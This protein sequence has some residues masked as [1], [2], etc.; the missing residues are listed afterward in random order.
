MNSMSFG[1]DFSG[2]TINL[3]GLVIGGDYAALLLMLFS[4]CTIAAI[5]AVINFRVFKAAPAATIERVPLKDQIFALGTAVASCLVVS[6][7]IYFLLILGM[8]ARSEIREQGAYAAP[9]I[10]VGDPFTL[11]IA[12]IFF[13]G[14]A[15]LM[16]CA[17]LWVLN[18][19]RVGRGKWLLVAISVSVFPLWSLLSMLCT[20]MADGF[21]VYLCM[22]LMQCMFSIM[23]TLI[24]G[25]TT[26]LVLRQR[27]VRRQLRASNA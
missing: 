19:M 2:I 12:C 8:G 20:D 9:I 5:G 22:I 23:P 14:M 10:L 11:S 6:L 27:N 3:G 7:G 1:I 4:I 21:Q 16:A 24:G 15:S 13:A 17:S 18:R 25:L 26:T